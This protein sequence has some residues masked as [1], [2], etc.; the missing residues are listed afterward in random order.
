MYYTELKAEIAAEVYAQ[1]KS[2]VLTLEVRDLIAQS[3]ANFVQD[4]IAKF[5]KGQQE[6]GGDLRDRDLKKEIG[7]EHIDMFWYSEAGKWP[8]K[9]L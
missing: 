9:P 6:H 2:K 1:D 8:A 4:A 3:L 7:M 5:I